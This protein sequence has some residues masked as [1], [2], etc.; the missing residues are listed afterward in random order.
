MLSALKTLPNDLTWLTHKS[1]SVKA[2]ITYSIAPKSAV[3]Q[4]LT[5]NQD[6]QRHSFA[7]FEYQYHVFV[8]MNAGLCV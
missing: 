4:L 5:S 6:V 1:S 7:W 3:P 8:D 2:V